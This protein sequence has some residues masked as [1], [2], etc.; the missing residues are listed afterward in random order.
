MKQETRG[1]EDVDTWSFAQ[2]GGM[3]LANNGPHLLNGQMGDAP[4]PI[5]QRRSAE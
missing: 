2:G 4:C 1:K 3:P 5:T